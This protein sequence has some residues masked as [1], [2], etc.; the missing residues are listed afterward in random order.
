LALKKKNQFTDKK[1]MTLL[2]LILKN[3]FIKK[4]ITDRVQTVL[5]FVT[6]FICTALVTYF[7]LFQKDFFQQ[8]QLYHFL[9]ACCVVTPITLA[10]FELLINLVKLKTEKKY[11]NI[12]ISALIY[13]LAHGD[14]HF[15]LGQIIDYQNLFSLLHESSL[16]VPGLTLF[17]AVLLFFI[18][19][20]PTP[21][22]Q[23]V[24]F[25]MI[26]YFIGQALYWKLAPDISREMI[27]V[28]AMLKAYAFCLTCM[29]IIQEFT[30]ISVSEK[31][32]TR[33]LNLVLQGS[34]IGLWEWNIRDNTVFFDDMWFKILGREKKDHPETLETF[35]E[36]THPEDAVRAFKKIQ[37]AIEQNHQTFEES[38]R[39]LHKNGQWRWIFSKAKYITY[40]S[41]QR[42][43]GTHS[44]ITETVHMREELDQEKIKTMQQK[45]LADLGELAGGIAHEINNPL[46]VIKGNCEA[47]ATCLNKDE[48][49]R[50]K[51]IRFLSNAIQTIERTEKIVKGLLMLSRE[52][53]SRELQLL[54]VDDI[55]FE[56]EQLHTEACA[57]HDV[58]LKILPAPSNSYIMGR[59][60]QIIQVLSNLI[61]NAEYILAPL[62]G[63]HPKW[64]EI[65]TRVHEQSLE[66]RVTDSGPGLS[67]D[68]KEKI[69]R[70][71]FT[72]KSEG[73]GTGLGL[74]LCK[75]IIEKH[76]G[77]LTFESASER[78]QFLITFP[79]AKKREII[80]KSA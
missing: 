17:G 39:M 36:L 46:A 53:F 56:I 5:F 20:D 9:I 74:N 26:P 25:S 73:Q 15:A 27:F 57:K 50:L 47:I 76:Y 62:P 31:I 12:I 70:P 10:F 4:I 80:S 43:L 79:L 41:S 23:S 38:F 19:R 18:R 68:I 16:L 44:D 51:V 34:S 6:T 14:A 67:D 21:Y 13:L 55:L 33:H 75:H 30:D 64:I 35:K 58:T 66:I 37:I 24:L 59:R 52:D 29:G 77:K 40:A 65:A 28:I 8:E 61:K 42:F 1:N 60:E 32:K 54:L 7:L 72:T 78:T 49:P 63:E 22:N 3:V 2:D 45:R 69:M 48:I 71:F 11:T